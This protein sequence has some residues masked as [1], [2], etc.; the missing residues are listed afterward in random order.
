M[1]K[2]M[3]IKKTTARLKSPS[4]SPGKRRAKPFPTVLIARPAYDAVA[5]AAAI[6]ILG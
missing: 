5:R 4:D 1:T 3:R 6:E 2:F